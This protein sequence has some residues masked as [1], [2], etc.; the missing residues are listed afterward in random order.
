M[1]MINNI[2]FLSN[3]NIRMLNIY[4]YGL[5]ILC[6]LLIILTIFLFKKLAGQSLL[7][8]GLIWYVL[9]LEL[10]FGNMLMML[11]TYKNTIKK[12]GK[13]GTQGNIGPI[14]RPGNSFMCSQCGLAGKKMKPIYSTNINDLGETISNNEI[15]PGKCIFPFMHNNEL[16]YKCVKEP[17]ENN[18]LNDATKSGWCATTL[19]GD[20]TYKTYGYCSFSDLEAKRREKEE[21]KRKKR[22]EYL[23]SNTGVLD[24]KVIKS[25]RSSVECPTGYT[26]NKTD[27]NDQSGGK[28]IY[29]CIKKGLGSSGINEIN[30]TNSSSNYECPQKFRKIPQNLNEGSGGSQIYLC[31]NKSNKNFLTDLKIQNTD[32]CPEDYNLS[33]INLNEGSGGKPVYLCT[34]NKRSSLVSIDTAFSWGKNKKTYFFRGDEFWLFDDKKQSINSQYPK[35]ISTYWE[36]IPSNIDAVFTWAK[37][38]STYFFKGDRFWKFDDKRLTIAPSYP[39]KIKNVWKGVPDNINSVFSDKDGSTYFLKGKLYWKFDDKQNKVGRGYPRLIK[40]R[41]ENSP[42]FINAMFIYEYEKKVVIISNDKYW[43]IGNDGTIADGYPQNVSFK[44]KGLY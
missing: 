15:R 18:L 13:K 14:G 42:D 9:L 7:Q 34:S 43:M 21:M 16:Q 3:N 27:L 31:K 29:M 38:N 1:H 12:V 33:S 23:L 28:Y 22:R 17:R 10:N 20:K 36:G 35:K 2:Y 4:I 26:K 37:D 41:W 32:K 6:I 24:L 25:N 39:K 44:F 8:I 11:I 5:G 40:K 19:K 30:T